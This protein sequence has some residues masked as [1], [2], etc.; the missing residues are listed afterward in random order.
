[1]RRA[2]SGVWGVG[3]SR[4]RR[5]VSFVELLCAVLILSIVAAGAMATWNLSSRTPVNKRVTETGSLI[6]VREIEKIKAQKY[7]NAAAPANPG[8]YDRNGTFLA[9]AASNPGTAWYKSV[10]TLAS[11]VKD[12][13]TN[14]TL[15]ST[16]TTRDLL[17]VKVVVTNA[18]GSKTYETQRTLMTFGG[19]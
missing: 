14:T 9:Y 4:G 2:V 15:T 10:T 19:F 1:M 11:P 7:I 16:S 12:P 6:A 5:G 13:T 17:E 18:A 8:W 3:S